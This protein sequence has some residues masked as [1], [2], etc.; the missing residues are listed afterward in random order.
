MTTTTENKINPDDILPPAVYA[1][2]S[3]EEVVDLLIETAKEDEIAVHRPQPEY[4][5]YLSYLNSH[6]QEILRRMSKQ[7]TLEVG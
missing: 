3:N 4:D 7:H 2:L 5:Y 1:K 6:K